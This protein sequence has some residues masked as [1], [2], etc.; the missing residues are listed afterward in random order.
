MSGKLT[1]CSWPGLAEPFATAL[2]DAV[3]FIC[4]EVDAAGIV[5][6]GTIVRGTPHR[7]SDLDLYVLHNAP[8]RRRIQRFFGKH[9]PTEIFINP[10]FAIR[11]YFAEEH[12][13]G[14]PFT[15]HMLATGHVVFERGPELQQLRDEATQWLERPSIPDEAASIRARYGAATILEDAFDVTAVDNAT[16]SM[17]RSQAVVAMLEFWCR[18]KLGHVPRGKDMLSRVADCE[19]ILGALARRVFSEDPYADR[20]AA[21]LELADRILGVRGF[22]EWDSEF[23]PVSET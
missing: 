14:R 20:E 4:S 13:D 22:F 3:A 7:S 9:V 11:S 5:A 8:L 15:A 16:S 21:S 19:P 23:Q 17:L 10:P 18:V 2:R 6:A 1:Q 12:A